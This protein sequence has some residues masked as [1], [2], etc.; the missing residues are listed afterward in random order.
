[1]HHPPFRARVNPRP[2]GPL[3]VTHSVVCV[4]VCGGGAFRPPCDLPNYLPI[5]KFQT[6]FDSP[7]R[8][9]SKHGEKF[10]LEATDEVTGQIK[11][12]MFD[13]WGLV[14]STS[15]ISMFS[16]NKDICKY[17][18]LIL[19]FVTIIQVKVISGHQVKR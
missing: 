8:E 3:R 15:T 1:M 17:H 18:F 6:P 12:R 4:C 2:V 16:A 19:C 7:V 9:L 11:V 13:F 14:T 5:S 10:D